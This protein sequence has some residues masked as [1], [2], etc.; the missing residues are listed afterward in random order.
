[1][2]GG[3]ARM[4]CD[5]IDDARKLTVED[6][7]Q[8]DGVGQVAQDRRARDEPLEGAVTTAALCRRQSGKGFPR[9]A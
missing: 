2:I 8:V 3:N 4:R 9:R 6:A 7:D 5:Q 1:M